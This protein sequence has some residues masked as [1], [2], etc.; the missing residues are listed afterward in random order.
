M[1]YVVKA[2]AFQ[3]AQPFTFNG[4]TKSNSGSETVLYCHSKNRA[5]AKDLLCK[6]FVGRGRATLAKL[7]FEFI[8]IA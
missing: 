7:Q 1:G 3:Y 8:Q 2:G 4:Y 5:P 6:D